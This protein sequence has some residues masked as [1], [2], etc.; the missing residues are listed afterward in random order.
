ML[1]LH[2]LRCDFGGSFLAPSSGDPVSSTNLQAPPLPRFGQRGLCDV[3]QLSDLL[4]LDPGKGPH[5]P[6]GGHLPGKTLQNRPVPIKGPGSGQVQ[7]LIDTSGAGGQLAESLT[8][9]KG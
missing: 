6:V 1:S 9:T 8:Q 7:P 5:F 4:K 3:G 2:L